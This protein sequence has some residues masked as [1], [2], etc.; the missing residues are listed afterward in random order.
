MSPRFAS[1]LI[2]AAGTTACAATSV[3]EIR[4]MGRRGDTEALHRA[5]RA[6]NTEAARVAVVEEL[7]QHPTDPA[8]HSLVV[9]QARGATSEPLKRAATQALERY[10]TPEST[11]ALIAALGDPW[12]SIREIALAALAPRA[13]STRGELALAMTQSPSPL[14]RAG[15]TKLVAGAARDAGEDRGKL[16]DALL[17]RATADDAPKVRENAVHALGLLRVDRARPALVEL[18]RTDPDAGV[19]MAA[20]R[21]IQRLG[22]APGGGVV[23]AVLPIQN[24]TGEDDGAL[25]R[26]GAELAEY[27]A[28]HLSRERVC[29][30][31]DRA[32]LEEA[33]AELRKVGV[34]MYDGD[35]PNA[36]AIGRF[37][38]ANQLVYGSIHRQGAL[39]SIVLE[40]IDVAT[41]AHVPGAAVTVQGYRP[42][43]AQL[44][45]RAA[46]A[47]ARGFR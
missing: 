14:V 8:G 21:S 5:W 18:M 44:K 20:E 33:I 11:Q 45:V 26:F 3:P 7:S 28:A 24:R 19:R 4:E 39:Y 35:A 9:A 17:E 29:Q 30:V 47:L 13:A 37:K 31:V 12:P 1:C 42:D 27:V 32:K 41:L 16:E 22:G 38:I 34:A 23:V 40:R 6:V 10:P 2:L 43:L 15:A 46:D 36:P 25:D